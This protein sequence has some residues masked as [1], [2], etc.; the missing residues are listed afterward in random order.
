MN[1]HFA[2]VG[3]EPGAQDYEHGVQV[4]DDQKEF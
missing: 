2:S 4:I 1:G 3:A